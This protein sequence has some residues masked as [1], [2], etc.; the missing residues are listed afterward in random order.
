MGNPRKRRKTSNIQ[1]LCSK[2]YGHFQVY[3]AMIRDQKTI[4]MIHT[5]GVFYSLK[6]ATNAYQGKVLAFIGD[7]RATKEPSPICLPQTKAW[8]WFAG[9]ASK[10]AQSFEAHSADPATQGT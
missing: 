1:G 8:Q 3:I 5:L 7:R 4:T 6:Q 9:K 10:D 2:N